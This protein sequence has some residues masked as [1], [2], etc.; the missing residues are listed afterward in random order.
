LKIL[1]TPRELMDRTRWD[2][3]CD[4]L[5]INPWAVNEGR[6]DGDEELTLTEEQAAELGILPQPRA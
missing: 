2:E 1:I 5:G 4:L 6:M 3:A